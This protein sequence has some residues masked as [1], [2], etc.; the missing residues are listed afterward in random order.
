MNVDEEGPECGLPVIL[1]PRG[2]REAPRANPI[3]PICSNIDKTLA[4]AC[5]MVQLV[6]VLA[7]KLNDLS[8]M[9]KS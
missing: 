5:K 7:T 1:G 2:A 9:F 4:R 3:T 8:L 6:K